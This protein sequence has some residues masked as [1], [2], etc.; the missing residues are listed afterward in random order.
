[1]GRSGYFLPAFPST[2]FFIGG[3]RGPL[4]DEGGHG[5]MSEGESGWHKVT[6][7]PA[8]WDVGGCMADWVSAKTPYYNPLE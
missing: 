5:L 1:V 6:C 3:E 7:Q 8:S 4:V 2:K